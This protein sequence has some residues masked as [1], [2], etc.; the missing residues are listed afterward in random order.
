MSVIFK[1]VR[2]SPFSPIYKELMTK[3]RVKRMDSFGNN[4]NYSIQENEL[5]PQT[6]FVKAKNS[7]L[8]QTLRNSPLLDDDVP[9]T[10]S[11]FSKMAFEAVNSI[12][13]IED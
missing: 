9:K 4:L 7:Q 10:S 13:N 5:L 11:N 1:F 8:N 6:P 2:G 3:N 12:T